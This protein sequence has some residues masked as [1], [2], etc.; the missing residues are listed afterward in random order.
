MLR[1]ASENRLKNDSTTCCLDPPSPRPSPA[2][3]EGDCASAGPKRHRKEATQSGATG[4]SPV[5]GQDA[6]GTLRPTRREYSLPLRYRSGYWP[7]TALLGATI[8]VLLP[9]AGVAAPKKA[10][11]LAAKYASAVKSGDRVGLAKLLAADLKTTRALDALDGLAGVLAAG[12]EGTPTLL[13]DLLARDSGVDPAAVAEVLWRIAQ[14][15][16]LTDDRAALSAELLD[17]GDPFVRAL[18][19]WA[20]ATKVGRENGGQEICWPRPD[21]PAWFAKWSALDADFLLDA[22][23]ARLAVVWNVHYDGA[24]LLGSVG[25]IIGRARGAASEVAASGS[26]E[27]Q[28][29]VAGQLDKLESIRRELARRVDEAPDD[30]TDHRRLWLAARRAARPIV[31]ANPA[32]DFDRLA[33]TLR[34]PVHS[35]RNITGSQYPW[36][37]KPG[38][39][40][41]VKTGLDP[42]GEVRRVLAGQLGPGHV[43]GMDLWWDADRVVFAFARQPDWPPQWDAVRG[44]D[45]F[46]LRG[47]QEPT[48]LYEV[49]LDGTGLRQ[50]TDHPYWSDLEPTYCADGRVV[51]ASD[52][53]GRS[54]ECGRFSADH[55][56]INLYAVSP[57]GTNLRRLSDNKDIDRYPHSLD[58]GLIAYTRWEYQERHFFEVHAIWQV[59]PDGTKAD[60]LFNQHLR[61]PFGLRDTRSIP[62]SSKLVSIATGH[63]TLAYGPV[64]VV[65]PTC[66]INEPGAIRSVTPYSLPQEGPPP[67][68]AAPQGGVPDQGGLYQTPWALSATC[69]LASYSHA[70]PPSGTGGGENAHGFSLYLI[71]VW[72]N[73]E[74]I[75]RD[76]VYSCSF[77]MPV[78]RRRRPTVVPDATE[79]AEK[80]ATCYVGDVY[81]GLDGAARGTVKHLRIS[82]RIGWPL[83]AEVGA[84]RWIPG[85]AW[86]RKFGFWA[87][88]PVRVIGEVP[89][90]PDGSAHFRVPVDAAVYFQALDERHMEVRRMR[91]HIS[92]QPGERRGCLGCHE[93][94]P[95][96]PAVEWSTTLALSREADVPQPPPWGADKLLGYEW[97][98][99]PIFDRHCTRCHGQDEPDGGIDLTASVADDG[100]YQSYRTLFGKPPEGGK[101]GPVFVSVSNRF[102]GAAITQPRQF[103]S[104]KSRLVD[105]LLDELHRKEVRLSDDEWL[106][107][108]TWID[109]N[110][111][112]YDT[113][114]NRRPPDGGEPR[115]DIRVE[116]PA[117]SVARVPASGE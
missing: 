4:V 111:P 109:A 54:S 116:F 75:H 82:Q 9:G 83:D 14:K 117:T 60:A 23:Y 46:R 95:K 39:D 21:A 88:A 89:V 96:T 70:R 15:D 106:T 105:V 80:Y 35:H 69:F 20:I 101:D 51:F 8:L 37:H 33:F 47:E 115:R 79:P 103:G 72:G 68:E 43:H 50:I 42:G 77:P 91:S 65:D 90:E 92:F 34:H 76:P 27:R 19:E 86:E 32:I 74:L 85:N 71:D 57:D 17:H 44:N 53:S 25:A 49:N 110:A 63:H 104:H 38:G 98:V 48:H 11:P 107:L 114:F 93:T 64:V 58:N 55:T 10:N 31:M 3:G 18:A 26:P 102:D 61:A 30:V 97:L 16:G 56:V 87:W 24:K 66:G 45:V 12:E 2:R 112:Y 100:F 108:V 78:K 52:R 84:M 1:L 5:R 59:R 62:G 40:V 99:Q 7:T 113:F 94:K 36:C 73:K 29:L 22:D 28:A 81:H 41:C 13:G 67:G 6:R